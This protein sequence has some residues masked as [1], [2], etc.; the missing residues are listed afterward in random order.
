MKLKDTC[1]LEES[2]DKPSQYIKKQKH[3]F[4]EKGL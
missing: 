1:S 3:H 2:Y 4:A